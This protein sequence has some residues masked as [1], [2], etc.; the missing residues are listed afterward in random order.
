V[1]SSAL[2][3]VLMCLMRFCLTE[4]EPGFT[5]YWHVATGHRRSSVGG[6]WD[7][8]LVWVEDCGGPHSDSA[9]TGGG[10]REPNGC[11]C[12]RSRGPGRKADDGSTASDSSDEVDGGDEPAGSEE[13]QDEVSK[14]DGVNASD[15][16]SGMRW[17]G[18]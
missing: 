13:P 18:K 15:I 14:D 8:R 7:A 11:S 5:E 3:I 10:G 17:S 4:A 9:V 1:S 6:L 12:C 2:R 16:W